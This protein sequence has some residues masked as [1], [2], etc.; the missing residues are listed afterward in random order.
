M[1]LRLAVDFWFQTL[2]A[3]K[4]T[5]P[6]TSQPPTGHTWLW[7]STFVNAIRLYPQA[8]THVSV[9][10]QS[11]TAF[12]NKADNKKEKTNTEDVL[13]LWRVE[14]GCGTDVHARKHWDSDIST[15]QPERGELRFPPKE[16]KQGAAAVLRVKLCVLGMTTPEAS[17]R[18][19]CGLWSWFTPL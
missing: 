5:W 14:N 12:S 13:F 19:L 8:P 10:T 4:Q 15:V 9:C 6:S 1:K 3:L 16:K 7:T 2:N 11:L 17:Y 18:T